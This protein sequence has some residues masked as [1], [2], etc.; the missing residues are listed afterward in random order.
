[1]SVYSPSDFLKATSRAVDAS[2][3]NFFECI[4]FSFSNEFNLRT[5]IYN[6]IFYYTVVGIFFS[7]F[8]Y[9]EFFAVGIGF[10]TIAL[11]LISVK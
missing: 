10:V 1:M 2:K 7:S 3:S 8:T 9:I 4:K 6:G 5:T 11:F